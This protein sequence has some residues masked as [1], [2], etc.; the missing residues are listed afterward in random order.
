[1]IVM[2]GEPSQAVY[3][4]AQGRLRSQRCSMEGREYVLH[5]LGPGECFNLASVLDGG[6]NLSTVT[7][8][9]DVVLYA[10]PTAAFRGIVHEHPALSLA[11]LSHLTRRVR[12]LSD[13]VEGLALY[14]VRTRLARCLLSY[15]SRVQESARSPRDASSLDASSRRDWT[16]PRYLTQGELAA[17][18]GTVRDVV[19]RTLRSFTQQGLIRRERGQVVITDLAGLRREALHDR[20]AQLAS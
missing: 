20:G 3:F 14:G 2:A 7:A 12:H 17:Q 11:L 13:A 9:S 19:G 8:V 6:Y 4:V 10:I 15:S 5:D 16:C 18:I 1:M